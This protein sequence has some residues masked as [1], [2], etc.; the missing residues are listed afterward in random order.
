MPDATTAGPN[1]R[2][3]AAGGRDLRF[4]FMR[5]LAMLSLI[6][7]HFEAFAWPNFL[8]WERLGIFTGAELFVVTAGLL[9]GITSRT[10]MAQ[11]GIGA[12]A[13][14]LL[15]RGFELYRAA[16]VL[17]L[18]VL[19]WD[20]LGPGDTTAATTFTDRFTGRSYPLLP[21][22]AEPWWAVIGRIVLLRASPHQMQI[23]GL[24]VVLLAAAPLML[25][26]LSAG[27]HGL[28]FSLSWALYF[29]HLQQPVDYQ[30]LGMQFEYAFPP[31]AWQVLF[32]H[33]VAI[34]YLRREIAA[35][36]EDARLRR[37]VVAAGVAL[38]AG[39]FLFAQATPN[40]SFPDW[41]RLP[42]LSAETFQAVYDGFFAKNR[43]GILR[44]ANVAAFFVAFYALLT[45]AWRPLNRALGW[46][47][48]PLG[49]SS[50]YV[51]LMHVPA[52]A[53]ADQLPGYFDGMP[54][55]DP[56]RIWINTAL[57]L[58]IVLSLWWLVERRVLFSI[59]PR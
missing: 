44:I 59:V 2:P 29:L 26:L 17:V 23:L 38:W 52:L 13:A 42:L 40:P 20:R 11:S 5:G 32:S 12:V 55:F 15:R 30:L 39:F 21:A 43:L 1:P 34:G 18:L 57:W 8:F 24:Y 35:L 27:L 50:L 49:R 37:L 9:I 22:A 7:V 6:T 45:Y 19:L 47:L 36:L 10:P 4:D 53:L 41:A 56:V 48:L 33:A 3:I 58:A 14:R 16:V 46:L 28:Y 51:F 25:W 54:A 31:L